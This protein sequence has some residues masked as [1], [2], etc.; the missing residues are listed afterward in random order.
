[1][2]HIHAYTK[3]ILEYAVK[4]KIIKSNPAKEVDNC[5]VVKCSKKDCY[6][7]EQIRQILN[8][9]LIM[10]K[11]VKN[12]T[13][14]KKRF[15]ALIKVALY[16]CLRRSEIS[17]LNWDDLMLKEGAL[18]VER[19]ASTVKG[20]GLTLLE[21]KNEASEDII[22][23]SDDAIKSLF[24]YKQEVELLFGEEMTAPGKAIFISQS[25][26]RLSPQALNDIWNN[27]I[28]TT[29]LPK[30]TFHAL[31]HSGGTLILHSSKDMKGT[32]KHLRHSNI[33]TT[34]DVYIHY[35]LAEE[36]KLMNRMQ[37]RINNEFDTQININVTKNEIERFIK[38][39]IN[40]SEQKE[41]VITAE[42]LNAFMLK[43]V[44]EFN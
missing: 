43:F 21:T 25:G 11:F 27:Y 3:A 33:A 40:N 7:E 10:S 37:N 1:M 36:K 24:E 4:K 6:T 22:A 28:N 9:D 16:G 14:Y 44:K 34:E 31:R 15:K 8:A 5:P 2:G 23:L 32:S 18:R 41:T 30:Y 39:F 26:N 35:A 12:H 29:D 42:L 19:S 17:G 38:N 20:L 13:F